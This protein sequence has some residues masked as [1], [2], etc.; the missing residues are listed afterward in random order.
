MNG[1]ATPHAIPGLITQRAAHPAAATFTLLEE[2]VT[3]RGL[4]VFARVDHKANAESAG[5]DMPAASVLI[6]GNAKAGTPLMLAAPLTAFDL[7]LRVLVWEDA[8]GAAWVSYLSPPE[9]AHRYGFP[10]ELA[11]NL[12][13]VTAIVAEV[14][15]TS[16]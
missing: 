5:L 6:F 1:H 3:R 15:V 11:R 2:A 4:T 10:P 16:D 12:D 8:D 7:P 14:T 13:G 9:L